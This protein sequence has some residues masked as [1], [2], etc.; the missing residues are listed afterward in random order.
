MKLLSLINLLLLTDWVSASRPIE[1]QTPILDS[2]SS[3]PLLKLHKA[4]IDI[5]SISGN[6][7]EVGQYLISYLEKRNFTV[8][9]QDVE[10]AT[11]SKG[12]RRNV[13]A[14]KGKKRKTRTLVT[15]HIDTVPP[16]LPYERK[17]DEIWGRGSVDAKGSVTAQI[18]AFEELYAAGKISEGD[19]ALLFVVGEEDRGDGMKKANDLGLSWETVIFGEPTE[20]KLSSGH[21]G[22]TGVLIKAKGKAGHSGY[23]WLGK[24]AN[25]MLIPALNALLNVELPWSEKYGNT[26]LNIGRIEG[27]VAGNVIPE[28]AKANIAIRI[29]DGPPEAVQKIV[30]DTIQKA[31]EVLDV[32][33][34]QGYGPVPID[35]DVE[36]RDTVLF[37]RCL[38]VC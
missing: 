6:E 34:S 18:A 1:F 8:E 4:L 35:A 20:L 23:P 32:S 28:D 25:A 2:S 13:F 38:T 7:Q 10:A 27:G 36:G 33:F 30:L 19:V 15:S 17:G 11:F 22:M 31:G 37:R 12:P 3:T 14:F 5:E 21:K 29:A 9:T 16:Y 26:T 24:S